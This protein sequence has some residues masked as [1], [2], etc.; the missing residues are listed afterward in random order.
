MPFGT[1]DVGTAV[2]ACPVTKSPP[3]THWIEIELIG[4]DGQPIPWMEY[5]VTLP[6]GKQLR[7]YLDASGFSR[8]DAIPQAGDCQVSFPEFDREAWQFIGSTG[9]KQ[10]A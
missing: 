10:N 5:Q 2:A 8:I 1:N 3:E 9:A 6:D 4:E 7:G